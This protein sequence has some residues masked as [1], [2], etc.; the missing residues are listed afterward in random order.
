MIAPIKGPMS[1]RSRSAPI[2]MAPNPNNFSGNPMIPLSSPRMGW[3]VGFSGTYAI[4]H[5]ILWVMFDN[6]YIRCNIYHSRLS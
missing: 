1:T 2:P 6:V 4:L 3:A 5:Y